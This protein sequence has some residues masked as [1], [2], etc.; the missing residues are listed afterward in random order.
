MPLSV[1]RFELVTTGWDLHKTT[2]NVSIASDPEAASVLHLSVLQNTQV[3]IS[4]SRQQL[5]HVLLRSEVR[6][7]QL[8]PQC[9]TSEYSY[10]IYAR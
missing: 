4:V 5:Q 7:V 10:R 8:T 2:P 1:C 3:M 6:N 9:R